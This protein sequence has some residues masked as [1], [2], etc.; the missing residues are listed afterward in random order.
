[1]FTLALLLCGTV[2]GPAPLMAAR[3]LQGAAAAAMVPQVLAILHVTFDEKT[4]GT[5]FAPYGTVLS[6]QR[7]R[8][9]ARRSPHRSGSVRP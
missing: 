9:R 3:L 2:T 5:D 1:M 6:G 7:D 8:T 4:R